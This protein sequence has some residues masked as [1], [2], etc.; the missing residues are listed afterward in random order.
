[1]AEEKR[2]T[3][4]PQAPEPRKIGQGMLSE[5]LSR[6]R[7]ELASALSMPGHQ[8]GSQSPVYGHSR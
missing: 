1:M 3:A 4:Q 5:M 6:G 7:D 2:A 8:Q